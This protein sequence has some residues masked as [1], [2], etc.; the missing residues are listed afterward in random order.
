MDVITGAVLGGVS[1][2]GG[3]GRILNVVAGVLVMGILSNG[4]VLLN[5]DEYWQWV[6]KGIVLFVAVAF[7]NVQK[8]QG[9]KG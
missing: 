8:K 5:L 4:M 2:A 3:E 1:V 7:D 6:V 9:I